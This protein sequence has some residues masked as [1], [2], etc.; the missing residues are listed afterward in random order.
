MKNIHPIIPEKY[1]DPVYKSVGNNIFENTAENIFVCTLHFDLEEGDNSQ[2][3]LE[4]VLEEFCLYISDFFNN[5]FF[6][7][8]GSMVVELAGEHDDLQKAVQTIIGKRVYNTEYE[9]KDG[10]IY[11]KLVIE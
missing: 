5:D 11:V 1:Q 9:G 10:R 8:S 2:Y 6:N 7:Q 4:D 3:P